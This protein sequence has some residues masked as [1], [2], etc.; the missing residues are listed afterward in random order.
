M[1][2]VQ[3]LNENCDIAELAVDGVG[4]IELYK[5][6]VRVTLMRVCLKNGVQCEEAAISL[7]WTA[8]AWLEALAATAQVRAMVSTKGLDAVGTVLSVVAH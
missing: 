7:V 6:R 8:T 3:N 5:G 1:E 2:L 4:R